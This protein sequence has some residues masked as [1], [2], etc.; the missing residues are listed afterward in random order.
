MGY[1]L[2]LFHHAKCGPRTWQTGGA[3]VTQALIA[4]SSARLR[5]VRKA[6]KLSEEEAAKTA[7]VTIRTWRKWEAGGP[8]T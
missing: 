8:I 6:F 3:I 1:A 7:G 2:Q 4:N 5:R